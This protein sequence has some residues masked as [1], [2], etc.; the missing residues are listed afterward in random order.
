MNKEQLINLDLNEE[1]VA[2]VI[3]IHKK[4]L[5]GNY[6][7]KERFNEVNDE[8]KQLK[9]SNG[10]GTDYEAEISRLTDENTTLKETHANEL[11]ELKLSSN[12]D[13]ELTKSKAK[14]ASLIK[15]L[16]NMDEVKFDEEGKLTGLE[17]Q[18]ENLKKGESTK[19]L[20]EVEKAPVFKGVQ[21]GKGSQNKPGGKPDFSKMT[22]DQLDEYMRNN[23]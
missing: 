7:P 17:D 23:K 9:E 21:P 13:L 19:T 15:R 18:I 5:N 12:V 11:E 2:S 20:F 8:N 3:S 4:T 6:V 16:L 14:D 10:S 1:Q 22:Y